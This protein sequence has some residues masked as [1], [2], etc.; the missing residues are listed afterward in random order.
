[1]KN[2]L[3]VIILA[4]MILSAC[5]PAVDITTAPAAT[6]PPAATAA[7][8]PVDSAGALPTPAPATAAPAL[9]VTPRGDALEATDPRTVVIGAG[10]PMLVEFFAFW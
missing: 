6:P 8:S 3:G 5:A 7:P 1:M 2:T 10:Q 4:G 9:V